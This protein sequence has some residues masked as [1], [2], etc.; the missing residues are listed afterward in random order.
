MAAGLDHSDELFQTVCASSLESQMARVNTVQ[1]ESAIVQCVNLSMDGHI[2]E[3]SQD[4]YM[5][6]AMLLRRRF[7]VLK[8]KDFADG[9]QG[10]KSA[11]HQLAEINNRLA[12]VAAGFGN[13]PDSI[14]ALGKLVGTL[15]THVTLAELT[16]ESRLPRIYGQVRADSRT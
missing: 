3:R 8:A 11:N 12:E 5:E 2:A 9:D 15:D 6:K 14:A 7:A 13:I 10:V 4:Q 16:L 1:L